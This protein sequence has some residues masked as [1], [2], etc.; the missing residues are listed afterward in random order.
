MLGP[1]YVSSLSVHLYLFI[2]ELSSLVLRAIKEMSLSLLV[3]FVVRGEFMFV[4]V[5]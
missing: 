2:G 4:W 5:V 1:V 3:I